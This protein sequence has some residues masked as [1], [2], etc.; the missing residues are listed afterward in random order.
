LTAFNGGETGAIA[1]MR[2]YQ[3]IRQIVPKLTTD[4]QERP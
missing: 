1:E 3:S 2:N 4:S